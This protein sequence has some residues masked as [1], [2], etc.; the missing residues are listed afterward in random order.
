MTLFGRRCM[1]VLWPSF[2]AAGILEMVVFAFVSPSDLSFG[3]RHFDANPAAIYS[4]AFF[5]F[6][7]VSAL[8]S[9]LT[10]TLSMG[11]EELNN[12]RP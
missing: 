5:V 6:W 11:R 10:V 1:C 7:V 8:S 4:I 12:A 3:H 2:L 9:V